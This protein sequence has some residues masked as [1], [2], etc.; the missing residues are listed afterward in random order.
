M[1][2]ASQHGH[3]L[4]CQVCVRLTCGMSDGAA[5][6]EE[7]RSTAGSASESRRDSAVSV[8]SFSG[9]ASRHAMHTPLALHPHILGQA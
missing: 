2:N 1:C 9:A 3:L 6:P 4:L 5:A 8:R 7:R